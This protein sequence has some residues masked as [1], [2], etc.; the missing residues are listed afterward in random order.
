MRLDSA[1]YVKVGSVLLKRNE[2]DRAITA[3]QRALELGP[4]NPAAYELLFSCL[5][6]SG[7]DA[8]SINIARDGLAV[9]PF[10]ADFHHRLGLVL[11]QETNYIGAIN[12]FAYAMMLGPDPSESE[13]KLRIA[14]GL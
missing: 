13:S 11:A 3:G 14:L 7:R 1:C 5:R 9:S 6:K 4:E 8:E 10:D 12:H 2:L